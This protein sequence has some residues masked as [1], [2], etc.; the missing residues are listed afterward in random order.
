MEIKK[1][2][3]EEYFSKEVSSFFCSTNK[4]NYIQ[5]MN[6]N[7]SSH[8]FAFYLQKI[9]TNTLQYLQ[10]LLYCSLGIQLIFKPKPVAK[11]C[12]FK[13]WEWP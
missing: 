10:S 2:L 11:D 9:F 1:I 3:W 4:R 8:F 12:I 5:E 6:N 13:K 7:E